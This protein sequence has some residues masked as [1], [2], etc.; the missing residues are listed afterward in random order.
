MPHSSGPHHRTERHGRTAPAAR[1]R[2]PG[3]VAEH[4]RAAGTHSRPALRAA[5]GDAG[6]ASGFPDSRPD[7][8]LRGLAVQVAGPRDGRG[9]APRPARRCLDGDSGGPGLARTAR[10]SG[11]A[12]ADRAVGTR[13]PGASG[14]SPGQRG[15]G[16][17]P[18]RQRVRCRRD[19]G[20]RPGAGGG[21]PVRGVRGR[22]RDRRRGAHHG[23]ADGCGAR[24][25]RG[26][27][28]LR[29]GPVLPRGQR[30][31]ARADL[32]A[33]PAAERGAFRVRSHPVQVSSA[34]PDHRGPHVRH[35]G[36]GGR[37]ALGIPEHGAARRGA[38][39]GGGGRAR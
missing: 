11:A 38:L 39:P 10:S 31:A 16:G 20:H 13:R 26:G 4:H 3:A 9:A 14:T 6:V 24:G 5:Q 34:Q 30:R 35:C 18:Q 23:I 7:R 8:P 19:E 28:G 2:A 29:R 12:A 27:P 25:H 22:L 33:R 17:V 21:R 36:H 37:M 15:R 1:A 32:P